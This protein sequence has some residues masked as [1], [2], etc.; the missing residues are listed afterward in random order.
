MFLFGYFPHMPNIRPEELMSNFLE[1]V[2][3]IYFPSSMLHGVA[4]FLAPVN[5][6]IVCRSLFLFQYSLLT[7]FF[8]FGGILRASGLSASISYLGAASPSFSAPLIH[9]PILTSFCSLSFLS[10]L[11]TADL[12]IFK[13]SDRPTAVESGFEATV[14]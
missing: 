6:G 8:G 14:R 7:S 2:R 12:S 13:I 1:S 5:F 3:V 11:L 4:R 9:P 10:D